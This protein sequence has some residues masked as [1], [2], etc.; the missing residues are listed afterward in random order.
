M[1][2][3]KHI[4]ATSGGYSFSYDHVTLGPIIKYGLQLTDKKQPR[5]GYLGTAGGDAAHWIA[6]FYNACAG[7]DVVPSHLELFPS[8]NVANVEDYILS[9]DMLWVAGGSVANLLAVWRVHGLDVSMRKAWEQ[10]VV[11]A[12]QSAGSICW[13]I[14]GTTD[15]FGEE[16]R[17]ITNGLAL[18][19]YSNGVHYDAHPQRRSLLHT[20]VADG[21]LPEGYATDDG[22]ALH[23]VG[24]RL[25]K[26]IADT[27]YKYA[28]QVLK[29][30]DGIKEIKLEATLLS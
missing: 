13:H 14:G 28:Y 24:E 7:H 21:I 16:L 25:H 15:S 19:P 11:L 6:A 27:P 17:P 18:L 5:L 26:V 8:P 9:Q 3:E 30:P 23:Y 20:L 4:L 1:G 12:G 10:G 22:V 29:T 2:K